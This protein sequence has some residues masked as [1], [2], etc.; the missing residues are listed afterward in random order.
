MAPPVSGL[1][2]RLIDALAHGH[3]EERKFIDQLSP[4]ERGEIGAPRAWSAKDIIAH[5][6]AW[7]RDT[8]LI[9]DAAAHG[10]KRPGPDIE[11][12]NAR[13]FEENRAR[14]WAEIER[15][16]ARSH[17]ALVASIQS[18]PDMVLTD[19]QKAS[20]RKPLWKVALGDGCEHPIN[21][22]SD[23][24]VKRGN[25]DRAME[26]RTAALEM[27]DRVFKDTEHH[28]YALYNLG[29]LYARTGRAD[30]ALSWLLKA[31]EIDPDLISEMQR[32]QELESLHREP[33]YPVHIADFI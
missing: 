26:V 29:C 25:I 19:P 12:F 11:P 17:D 27:M 10:E 1:K 22:L 8:A 18:C 28:A 24:Y 15:D 2:A 31:A 32:D 7:K 9:L 3:A 13:V 6:A 30:A 21:H 14:P 20:D 5:L 16:M 33:G 4:A 23:F